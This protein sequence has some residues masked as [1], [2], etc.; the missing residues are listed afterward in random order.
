VK[1]SL[2]HPNTRLTGYTLRITTIK[3][4]RSQTVSGNVITVPL[5]ST[6][7][8]I[9][10]GQFFDNIQHQIAFAKLVRILDSITNM[11]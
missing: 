8:S 5:P 1:H 6:Y 10:G 4:N 9:D 11:A 3:L 2:I 7:P